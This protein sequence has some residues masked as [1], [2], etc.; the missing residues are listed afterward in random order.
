MRVLDGPLETWPT[1]DRATAVTIGVLDGVH[2]GHQTLL[3]QLDNALIKTVLT[4]DPHPIEVLA[5]GSDPRL[6]TTIDERVGLL[7]KQGVEVV[8]VL[9]LAEI[10]DLVPGEFVQE[11]LVDRLNASQVVVGSDFRFGRDRSG[12]LESLSASGEGSFDVQT[13]DLV[14]S[15]EAIVSSSRIRGLVEAGDV[16]AAARLLGSRFRMTNVVIDG[17]K[18]GRAIGFPTANLRPPKRK[19]MP[20]VGI[21]AAFVKV[22]GRVH[23]AA[24]N[25]GVR[26]TFG[27]GDLLVEAFILDFDEDLYGEAITVEFVEY[28]R[29][30]MKFDGIEALVA[31]MTND[32]ARAR[33][34]LESTHPNMS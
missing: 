8:G 11:V 29:T 21:Y 26:P 6:I 15:G 5:P 3:E 1:L 25:V 16:G 30:E 24:V 23:R 22:A 4:F 20:K 14:S 12:D 27:G 2:V 19:V 32:V 33:D 17:D 13:I 18:R 34:I 31:A 9:D 7:A 10:R 28:L